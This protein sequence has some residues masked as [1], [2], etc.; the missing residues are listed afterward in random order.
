MGRRCRAEF[1]ASRF[2]QTWQLSG[3][4]AQG[5]LAAPNH[6]ICPEHLNAVSGARGRAC[7]KW[8]TQVTGPTTRGPKGTLQCGHGAGWTIWGLAVS[9]QERQTIWDNK[10]TPEM[11]N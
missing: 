10:Q 2:N 8:Q 4:R 3:I 6:L 9:A 1:N 5:Q 7:L 11:I